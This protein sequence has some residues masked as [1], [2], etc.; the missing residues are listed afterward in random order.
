LGI[1]FLVTVALMIWNI[2]TGEY[3]ISPIDVVR[4]VLHLETAN[5]DYNF[6]VNVLRLPRAIV[7]FVVGVML[8]LSGAVMQ[9]LT[10][11]PL[12]SPDITG[13]TAGASMGAVLMILVWPNAGPGMLPLAALVGGGVVA[14]AI[15]LLAWRHGDS[16]MRLILVG[17]GLGSMLSAIQAILMLRADIEQLQRALYWLTGSIYART[18]EHLYAL[19]PWCVVL[20]PII[21]FSAR[22]LNAL[23]LGDEVAQG[24]GVPVTWQ[25]GLLLLASVGLTGAA[26][27]QVGAVGF[28]GLMA[29]HVARRLVGLAHEGALVVTAL[30][31]GLL[32]LAADFI[33]RAAFAPLEIP[34]GIIIALVGAP[35]FL[36]LL[37][38]QGTSL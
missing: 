28:V 20:I 24:V 8:A 33:G 1:T 9:T 19:L 15:Y 37:W 14:L 10:R 23:H 7:A 4:T 12:A 31:G 27:S 36:F 35:F 18:W 5:S 29:P 13:V 17:I 38:K 34:A 3:P 32:V 11:N 22:Q 25:R 16:P 26:I 21:L 30:V 6:V 2:G